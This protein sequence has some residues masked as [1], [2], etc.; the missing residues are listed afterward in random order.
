[1][2]L[3]HKLLNSIRTRGGACDAPC[4]DRFLPAL[5]GGESPFQGG[6]KVDWLTF[7]WYPDPDEHV[8]A[9]VHHFLLEHL[10][11]KV[12]GVDCPGMLG[13]ERGVRYFI[14]ANDGAMVH[15]GRLDFGGLHHKGRARFDLS[16]TGCARVRTFRPFVD[17][18][19]TLADYKLTRVDLAVDCLEGEFTVEHAVDWYESGDFHAGGRRPRHAL[20]GDW[21]EPH[22][23]RTFEVGRRENGKMLRAYEKGRQLGDP[24]STWTRFEVEIRNIDRD[25]PLDVL[26]D[27]DI[28]FAGAYKCLQRI[29]DVAAERIATHQ[30]EGEIALDKLVYHAR[31]SYGTTV[32]VLRAFLTPEEVLEEISRPG[33]PA[34]LDKATLGGF[35]PQGRA[36][37]LRKDPSHESQRNRI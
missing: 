32:H 11:N 12:Q 16:G 20:K 29:L 23:G 2:N 13:Y 17:W 5:T 36:L 26:T 8:P 1:M 27:C 25:V 7:T 18:L 3:L 4:P 28:Y 34:R 22:Y 6:A 21:L 30:K 35:Q 33:L 37:P 31:T 9:T 14:E 10:G 24:D 19:P 15:V